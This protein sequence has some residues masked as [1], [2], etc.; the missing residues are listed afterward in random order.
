MKPKLS[1]TKKP[2]RRIFIV[3]VHPMLRETLVEIVNREN[4]LT[5]CGEASDAA[6]AFEAISRAKPELVLVDVTVAGKCGL[7]LVEKLRAADRQIK[8]LVFCTHSAASYAERALQAGGNGYIQNQGDP[9][10]LIHA[11]REVLEGWS[12]VSGDAR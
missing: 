12:Y 6:Q 9:E 8:L 7:E 1:A 2:E 10:E 3:L 11:I 5:V 4:D